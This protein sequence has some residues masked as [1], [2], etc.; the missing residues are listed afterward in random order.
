MSAAPSTLSVKAGEV[1]FDSNT[2]MGALRRII[3]AA[4]TGDLD[5]LMEGFSRVIISWPYAGDPTDIDAWDE[6]GRE[7]F[8]E[9]VQGVTGAFAT[10]GEA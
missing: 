7:E 4:N 10:A 5:T 9:L 1:V 6:L 2:K 8:N 3:K